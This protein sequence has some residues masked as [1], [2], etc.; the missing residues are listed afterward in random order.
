MLRKQQRAQQKRLHEQQQRRLRSAQQI[1]REL[2]ENENKQKEVEAK[3]VVI[4][5][6]LR[7]QPT[8]GK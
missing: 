7:E 3:G 4:E 1:Q 8:Q 2:E 5:K 6:S